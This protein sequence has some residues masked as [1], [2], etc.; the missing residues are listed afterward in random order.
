MKVEMPQ[1]EKKA[2]AIEVATGALP[3]RDIAAKHNLTQKQ[4]KVIAAEVKFPKDLQAAMSVVRRDVATES[5]QVPSPASEV[6]VAAKPGKTKVK[7]KP[8]AKKA[9][10][11]SKAAAKAPKAPASET[12]AVAPVVKLPAPVKRTIA[13]ADKRVHKE[14]EARDAERELKRDLEPRSNG[15]PWFYGEKIELARELFK[16]LYVKYGDDLTKNAIQSATELTNGSM[17]RCWQ[18]L[19]EKKND[20]LA[21]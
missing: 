7:V 12:V 8:E 2:I 1:V 19:I 5:P 3:V 10:K 20:L 15:Q 14:F 21:S 17:K 4:V 13:A 16:K 9:Q 6:P 11:A 18:H